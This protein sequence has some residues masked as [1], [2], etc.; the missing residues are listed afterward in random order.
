MSLKSIIGY[1][2][3]GV[4]LIGL[5]V[6]LGASDHRLFGI[7]GTK[8]LYSFTYRGKPAIIEEEDR[9]WAK[10]PVYIK[11]SDGEIINSG[12]LISDDGKVI[13]VGKYANND[14]NRFVGGVYTV[15][16]NK[17]R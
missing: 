12:K 9:I 15:L 6:L 1:S 4:G 11:L 16:D 13:S 5:L 3:G 7:R 17:E 14:E 10:D 8:T 2:L